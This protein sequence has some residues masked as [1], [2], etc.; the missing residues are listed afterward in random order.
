M[1]AIKE[2]L[3]RQQPYIGAFMLKNSEEDTDV[4]TDKNDVYDVGVLA[5]ITSAFPSKDEKTGTET[6]TALLYPHRRIKID[7]L[8]PPNEEKEKSKEQ[9]KDTDTETTVV[10]DANNP[11]DQEST[12]PATPKLEDI[13]VERIPDSELQHHKRV[14]ATEEESEE[15]DDIQEGEDINPTEFL[16][17]YNVSLVNVLNL[18]DEPF[19][20][21][22]PVINAL[23]SEI[24]KVF[25]EISQ[26]NTMFREQIAT[27]SAS[28]Q[29][30]TT[31]IFEEPAR[32]ADFAAAVSA[33]E[34]DEL[35]DILSSLN[36]EHRLEKSLLV[37]KKELMNAELQ[38]KISKDVETKIQKRQREY[39]LMEQ[40][41]G[42]KRELGIDDGRDKLID[43]YKERIKSLKLPDSVQKIF[44]DEIT[45]LSTLETSMSEFG[46]IRNYLDWLTS[47]PWGKH[48]KEQYS[49]PRAKKILDEDHYG[50]VDVK[51]RILEFIAVGKLLGK[52]DGKIICFVGPQVLVKRP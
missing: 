5:Q 45:K 4:I 9:A 15:L 39:Y 43:T 7:E 33:G 27:F 24:L 22:S 40:L 50:M 8:F 10:E 38:N 47:I 49:I 34:E 2:M 28:I 51:D 23:T 25:K 44:D 11:E 16:K 6:M 41:K 3:D 29:S 1:K 36:I 19:D 35:Q 30:A 42:I 37:L 32:L 20:R 21:K 52:V 48:S 31:N 46:V 26:L 18:E 17:N 12:S 14:E 13:V